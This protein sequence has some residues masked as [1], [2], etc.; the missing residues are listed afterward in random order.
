MGKRKGC[1]VHAAVAVLGSMLATLA[2]AP[3][4]SA[5]CATVIADFVPGLH[6][7]SCHYESGAAETWTVPP[8]ITRPTFTVKGA[9]DATGGSGGFLSAKLPVKAGEDLD[10]AL[11]GEGAASS[12]ADQVEPLLIAEGGGGSGSNYASPEAELLDAKAPHLPLQW[13]PANG[14]I[15]VEWYDRRQL[16]N[17]TDPLPDVIVDVFGGLTTSFQYAGAKQTWTVPAG[18][19]RAT[20][21]L[22]GGPGESSEPRGHV[23]AGFKVSP[24]ETFAIEVGGPGD[25]TVLN[26]TA[27]LSDVVRAVG[28]DTERDN[29]LP[30]SASPAEEFWEGGGIG[31][32]AADGHAIVHYWAAEDP[33]NPTPEHTEGQFEAGNLPGPPPINRAPVC[34]VPML[35]GKPV[36]AARKMLGRADCVLGRVGRKTTPAQRRGRIVQQFPSAGAKIPASRAV[37]VVVGANR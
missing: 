7:I 23:L 11:G 18:I 31:S 33:A 19:S 5:S 15:T 20:F 28:G 30:A 32:K 16:F 14:S 37:H 6:A 3:Q 22:F 21:E 34:V 27:S 35:R 25:D 12:V 13:A 36:Q 1:Q 26:R 4:A 9:D 29:Y 8:D 17:L 24:G 2:A 10:L